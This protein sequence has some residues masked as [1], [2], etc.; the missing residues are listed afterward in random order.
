MDT[1][2]TS[3]VTILGDMWLVIAET[4]NCIMPLKPIPKMTLQSVKEKQIFKFLCY[5]VPIKVIFKIKNTWF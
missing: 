4:S 1:Y 2:S 3:S 5:F